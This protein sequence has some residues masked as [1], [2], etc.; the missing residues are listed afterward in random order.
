MGLVNLDAIDTAPG[1]ESAA[2]QS[3]GA[4]QGCNDNEEV[5]ATDG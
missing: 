1:S 2:N 4:V 3:S 5:T